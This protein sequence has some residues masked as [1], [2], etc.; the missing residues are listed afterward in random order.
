MK[1]FVR[2]TQESVFGVYHAANPSIYI[3]ID[4]PKA[5]QV[6]TKPEY[7]SIMNG[8]GFAVQSLAGTEVTGLGAT[9]STPLD[10]AQAAF[11]L[12]WASSRINAAQT[13]PW[14]TG[15][16]PGDLASATVDYAWSNTDDGSLRTKRFLGV[17]VA[18]F[19]VGHS[20]ENPIARLNLTLIGSTPQGNT[21]DASSDPTLTEPADTVFPTTPVLFQHL[22]GGFTIDGA[23]RSNFQSISMSVQNKTKAYFDEFRFA[24]M[25]R[26]SGRNLGVSGSFRLKSTFDDRTSY[27]AGHILGSNIAV[28]TGPGGTHTIT[29]NMGARNYFNMIDENFPLDEEI[30]YDFAI[31][32]MLDPTSGS[33]DF[34]ITVT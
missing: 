18:G 26:M 32:N 28:W 24:N 29:M 3:R 30:Y 25:V 34:A 10:Y 19:G 12:G 31:Q 2:I 7:W 21:Y 14:P 23:L 6:M 9:L 13:L 4:Q 5:F 33:T 11:L 15:E 20:R 17:K 1:R 27:E 8:S 22:R 16:I